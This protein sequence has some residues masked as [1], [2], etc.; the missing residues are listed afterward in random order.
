[1]SGILGAVDLKACVGWE[2]YSTQIYGK[3][4]V[5]R[6]IGSLEGSFQVLISLL[7]HSIHQIFNKWFFIGPL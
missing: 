2:Q 1:M 6:S 5:E 3:Y 7:I 4:L